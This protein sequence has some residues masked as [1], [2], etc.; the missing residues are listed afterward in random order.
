MTDD[1]DSKPSRFSTGVLLVLAVLGLIVL[2]GLMTLVSRR[3]GSTYRITAYV[4]IKTAPGQPSS[5]AAIQ[6]SEADKLRK[7]LP[8]ETQVSFP[9]G[10]EVLEIRL[11]G[12]R[13][14]GDA[15][16]RAIESALGAFIEAVRK[17]QTPD[18]ADA[19]D[20]PTARRPK[21]EVRV[22]QSPVLTPIISRFPF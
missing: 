11:D 15:D 10:G 3:N 13:E 14:N 22:I 18:A 5:S 4:Q 12:R 2:A 7:L 19:K 6:Y 1:G 9:G 20:S 16:V 21:V 8:S 17:N